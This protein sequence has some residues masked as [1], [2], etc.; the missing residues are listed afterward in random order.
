MSDANGRGW[1]MFELPESTRISKVVWS[2]D[3][4]GQYDD[5]LA[6]SY[7]LEAG[8]AADKLTTLTELLPPRPSVNSRQ[9]A[10]RFHPVRAKR[11]RFSILS[12]NSLEPCL[13]ELEVFNTARKNI[14][15]RHCDR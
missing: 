9:N 6:T 10:D 15:Y 2:R 11:L 5:R 12:T 3:R 13:D 4:E 7:T 8:L 1:V 14:A